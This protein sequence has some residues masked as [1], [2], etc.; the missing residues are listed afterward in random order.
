MIPVV[1][2]AVY[3]LALIALGLVSHRY[4]RGGSAD[5]FVASRS[6]G[7]FVLFMAVYGTTMTAFAMVG[8][9]AESYEIGIGT[10]GKLASWSA[11]VHSA[12]FFLVGVPLWSLGKRHGYMTQVEY[13][14]DRFQSDAIGYLLF[15]VLVGL[16]IPYVLI[17][18]LGAGSTVS[19]LTAGAFPEAF[20]A[21]GGAIPPALTTAVIAAVVLCYIFGGGARSAAWAN[22]FQ[23]LVFISMGLLA[24]WLI[25]SR[26]GGV[27]AASKLANPAKAVR[28]GNMTELQFFS[29]GLIP[30]SAA[31][32]PHL[33]QNFLTARSAKT[34]R[35]LLIGH[36][37]CLILTWLP[38]ILIGFWAT[39]ALMPDTGVLVVPPG[40]NPNAVLGLMVGKLT[41][42]LVAGLVGAGVLA[43]IMSSLD[44]QF[45][46]VG[47]MFTRDIVVHHFGAE[48]FSDRAL[49]WLARGFVVAIV[50]ITYLLTLIETRSI[51]ALGTWCFSGY[52]ALFPLV[53]AA[54]YWRRTTRVAALASV[55]ATALAWCVM[56]SASDYGADRKFLVAGMLP[57]AA[58]IVVCTV[59]VVGVS[60]FTK[61]PSGA[62]LAKFFPLQS[63]T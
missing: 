45:V 13:F 10:F 24:F 1:I 44:S 41:S 5:Y 19:G 48:R 52:A 3:L 51:F 28:E 32:F 62:T 59:T 58:L 34:F 61:P 21:T 47:T 57:V 6:L 17:G 42:P 60:L 39:G 14:R 53:I 30:L 25:S 26:L 35:L 54:L 11:L 12:C 9:T 16:V 15:P 33:F 63:P 49:V 37:V 8:S 27:E 22:T 46:S 7:P 40:A 18:L 23:T 43:A 31:M 4:F 38:C 2:I 56:F 29:Y 55:A 50:I 20:A 36:P